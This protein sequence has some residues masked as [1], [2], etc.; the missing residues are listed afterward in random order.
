MKEPT[1]HFVRADTW[2]ILM[3]ALI[4]LLQSFLSEDT[5][6][7]RI[8]IEHTLPWIVQSENLIWGVIKQ[9]IF[10]PVVI[11][12]LLGLTKY[13]SKAVVAIN[14]LLTLE[15]FISTVLLA[16]HL[17][18]ENSSH[19]SQLIRDTFLVMS[20]NLLIFSLWYWIIDC[21]HLR[22]WTMRESEPWDFL[23]PQRA[24]G[25][26]QFVN[27]APQY[28]DYLFLAFSTS[29][30][31]GPADTPPLSQRAKLLMIL[32]VTISVINITI[33]AGF[34]LSMMSV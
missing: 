4:L 32:Q 5:S 13:L 28:F 11:F 27:W 9:A 25:N 17:S 23:F 10:L 26:P 3:I 7:A 2:A 6:M 34:A 8:I 18:A 16:I 12:W 15:L 19:L 21:P 14:G 29:F 24:I 33:L 31:F 30:T 20:I 22:S 1:G